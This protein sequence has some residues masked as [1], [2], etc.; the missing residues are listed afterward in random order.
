MEI[1][2]KRM[3]KYI[4]T[5]GSITTRELYENKD[6]LNFIEYSTPIEIETFQENIL[7]KY[8]KYQENLDFYYTKSYSDGEIEWVYIG[9][10]SNK[11]SKIG[12]FEMIAILMIAIGAS[13]AVILPS[14]FFFFEVSKYTAIIVM[15]SSSAG[16]LLLILG[17]FILDKIIK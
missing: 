8:N 2:L 10:T 11:E 4:R 1:D 15:M 17:I 9:K 5:K 13:T 7:S 6:N 12:L 16:V 14:I 3:Q